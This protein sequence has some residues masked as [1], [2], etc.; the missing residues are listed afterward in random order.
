MLPIGIHPASESS[1]PPFLLSPLAFPCPSPKCLCKC[2]I[3]LSR[4][5]FRLSLSLG[6][7]TDF[8]TQL[9][10]KKKLVVFAKRLSSACFLN[11]WKKVV[12]SPTPSSFVKKFKTLWQEFQKKKKERKRES[13]N[14]AYF[15]NFFAESN[16]KKKKLL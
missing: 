7:H 4:R 12:E 6:G 10:K 14:G 11:A 16:K 8:L 13:S 5:L 3:L 1:K 2:Q 9:T 15:E